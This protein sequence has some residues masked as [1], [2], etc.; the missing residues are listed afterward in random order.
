MEPKVARG[1]A[2]ARAALVGNP[3]DGFGGAVLALTV[4]A[5]AAEVA[6]EDSAED[7]MPPG[8][9]GALAAAALAR[10]RGAHGSPSGG[11]R[12]RCKTSVPE[13]VGLG[14][15]SAIAIATG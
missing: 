13:R 4:G 5:F 14:G 8:G 9:E 7:Q 12:V 11:V 2:Q 15:S 10:L 6:A 1:R 3:S